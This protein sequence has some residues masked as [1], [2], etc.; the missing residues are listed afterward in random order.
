MTD[1]VAIFRTHS[2]IEAHIVRGLLE[3]HGVMSVISS[4]GPR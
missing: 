3:T 2:D 1:F 4:D